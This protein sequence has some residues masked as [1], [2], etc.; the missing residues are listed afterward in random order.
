MSTLTEWLG[1]GGLAVPHE[2]AVWRASIC[3]H[4]T[5]NR[6][7]TIIESLSK[8]PAAF[9]ILKTL[10]LKE[11][12]QMRVPQEKKLRMCSICKCCLP[13]KIHVPLDYILRGSTMEEIVEFEKVNCWITRERKS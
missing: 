3:V 10:E 6:K 1:D 4:C 2:Q 12:L 11:Q 8:G 7:A 5:K 13:L 9:A